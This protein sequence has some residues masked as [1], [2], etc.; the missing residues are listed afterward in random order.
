MLSPIEKEKQFVIFMNRNNYYNNSPD[1]K[2]ILE[3]E[4]NKVSNNNDFYNLQMFEDY[5]NEEEE[6]MKKLSGKNETNIEEKCPRCG[7][8]RYIFSRQER[9]SDEA[10]SSYICC[11]SCNLKVRLS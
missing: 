11:P 8:D 9:S 2:R 1:Q 4:I 5:K 10:R 7:S 6:A 3:E